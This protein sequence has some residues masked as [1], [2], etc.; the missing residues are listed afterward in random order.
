MI[1]D[2]YILLIQDELRSNNTNYINNVSIDSVFNFIIVNFYINEFRFQFTHVCN[3]PEDTDDI[4]KQI[5]N[6][7]YFLFDI[8]K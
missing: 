5:N 6:E 1:C 4:K 2:E 3:N 8:K 7:L